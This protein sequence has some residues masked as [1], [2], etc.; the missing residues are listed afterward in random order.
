MNR[1][2]AIVRTEHET[3]AHTQPGR[4]KVRSRLR[5]WGRVPL[6][7]EAFG[8]KAL[9][10]CVWC[11]LL[12]SKLHVGTQPFTGLHF[13]P[14]PSKTTFFISFFFLLYTYSIL[15]SINAKMTE[16]CDFKTSSFTLHCGT[17]FSVFRRGDDSSRREKK[18]S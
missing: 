10:L 3:H 13:F 7:T 1:T 11:P 2:Y 18:T 9:L 12:Q 8:R 5:S 14:F 6:P 15:F 16:R 4:T 17:V